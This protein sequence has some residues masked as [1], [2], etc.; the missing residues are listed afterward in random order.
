VCGLYNC[1]LFLLRQETSAMHS[2]VRAG[3]GLTPDTLS[4]SYSVEDNFAM[5]DVLGMLF[6]DCIIYMTI[7]WLVCVCGCGC[8]F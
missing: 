5:S 3:L 1:L 2:P 6:L 8:G 4:R 7:A